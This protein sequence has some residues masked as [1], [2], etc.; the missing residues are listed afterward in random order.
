VGDKPI[1]KQVFFIKKIINHRFLSC[2]TG[3]NLLS[4]IIMKSK[5]LSDNGTT[6][7]D[8][9]FDGPGSLIL[10]SIR[11]PLGVYGIDFSIKWVNKAM[12][13]IHQSKPDEM[14]GKNCYFDFCKNS[15]SC[16]ECPI[17]SVRDTGK[18]FFAERSIDFPDGERRWGK[19]RA[20]PVFN[21]E[22]ELLA[23]VLLIIETT[24]IQKKL[25]QEKE[26]ADYLS[27]IINKNNGT[28][29]KTN[30]ANNISKRETEVLRL[31]TEGYTNSRISELLS[32]SQNTVKRH[33]D[34]IF[35]KLGVNDR[36]QAAV[37]AIRNKLI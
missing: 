22:R 34:N 3:Y 26:Y 13:Y 25:S 4:L 19:V 17:I 12:A 18:A 9:L 20:Y 32:I 8:Q 10:Q 30:F 5:I 11:D 1:L 21:S 7:I 31:V 28:G 35:N 27:G 2:T 24:N 33:V 37:L 29:K 15:T 16:F 14:I 6:K 23:V 36:T